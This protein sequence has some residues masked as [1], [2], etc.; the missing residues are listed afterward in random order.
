MANLNDVYS[1]TMDSILDVQNT[2]RAFK[3]DIIAKQEKIDEL[4]GELNTAN[5]KIKELEETNNNSE[6]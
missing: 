6:V 2:I 1:S 5:L 3:D 4:T